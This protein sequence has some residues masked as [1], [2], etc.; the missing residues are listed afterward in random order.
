MKHLFILLSLFSCLN[1]KAQIAGSIDSTFGTNGLA[2]NTFPSFSAGI[3]KIVLQ[4][5]NK[6]LATGYVYLYSGGSTLAICRY[7]ENGN[8]DFSFGDKGIVLIK[9]SNGF[10][11]R[12][13]LLLQPNGRII[14]AVS[15]VSGFLLSSRIV[16]YRFLPN[17]KADITFGDNGAVNTKIADAYIETFTGTLQ[18]DGKI[19]VLGTHYGSNR[20]NLVLIRYSP[21]GVLDA[22]FGIDGVTSTSGGDGV[23]FNGYSVANWRM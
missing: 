19:V 13:A 15:R 5:D 17:G 16:L 2:T 12:S 14:V 1:A 3:T 7:Y 20:T 8:P 10:F 4:P 6:I 11:T 18:D 21:D 22:S 9:N 23:F